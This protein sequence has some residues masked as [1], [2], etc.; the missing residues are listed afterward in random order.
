MNLT[1]LH[2]AITSGNF[3]E[4]SRLIQQGSDVNQLD[5]IMGNTPLHIAAQQSST[6]WVDALLGAGAFINIQTPKHGVTPLMVAVW[7]GHVAAEKALIDAGAMTDLVGFDGK[8]PLML[9][10]EYRY[11]E[12]VKLLENK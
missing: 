12:I 1:E 2:Q 3:E 5:P 10:Q 7:H 8:T 11:S 4:F 9:A 6:M